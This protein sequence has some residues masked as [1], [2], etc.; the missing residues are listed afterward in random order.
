MIMQYIKRFVS[1]IPSFKPEIKG[2]DVVHGARGF[3]AARFVAAGRAQFVFR[4]GVLFSIIN[5]VF[6]GVLGHIFYMI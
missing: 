3:F 5:S 4:L 1:Q 2:L 6:A